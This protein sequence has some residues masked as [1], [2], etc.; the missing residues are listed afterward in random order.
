MFRVWRQ[1]GRL[2]ASRGRLARLMGAAAAEYSLRRAHQI[3]H[4]PRRKLGCNPRW[5]EWLDL[6]IRRPIRLAGPLLSLA[7]LSPL[8]L[9]VL[10][11]SPK[12]TQSRLTNNPSLLHFHFPP[13]RLASRFHLRLAGISRLYF[14]NLVSD[15]ASLVSLFLCSTRHTSPGNLALAPSSITKHF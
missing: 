1:R 6:F 13:P 4:D 8:S 14:I 12:N 5:R 2:L 15:Q 11:C 10:A 9:P 7:A 3:V